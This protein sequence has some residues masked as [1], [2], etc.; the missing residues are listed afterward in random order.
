[1]PAKPSLDAPEYALS[2]PFGS[3][4][5]QIGT[6]S[7]LSA[8]EEVELAFAIEAGVLAA[9]R[10]DAGVDDDGL[11]GDLAIVAAEGER[12]RL[13]MIQANLRLV[14]S[15]ARRLT[16]VD[17]SMFDPVQD[18][19][20]GLIHAVRK[21]DYRRGCKFST[22]ASWWI[23]QAITQG[24]IDTQRV[25]LPA[26]VA[27]RLRAC[28]ARR[29]ELTAAWGREPTPAELADAC[30]GTADEIAELLRLAADPVSLEAAMEADPGG[31]QLPDRH[32]ADPDELAAA[33]MVQER[34][35][36]A[37]DELSGLE[38]EVI[39]RR[40]GLHGPSRGR[41]VVAAELGIDHRRV[42]RV[43]QEALAALQS[44]PTLAALSDRTGPSHAG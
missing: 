29:H 37:L 11:R 17:A 42:R 18:G 15:L 21:F 13:R 35:W 39:A 1:M 22:Y 2:D 43:E 20:L 10:L 25:R 12:A 3:Y 24:M 27:T 36:A 14:V 40:F 28:L 31:E 26:K 16:P 44:T 32:A 30:G 23:R 19:T 5:R 7:L 38:R 4:L 34:V 41:R 33:A 8:R 9:A 6:V